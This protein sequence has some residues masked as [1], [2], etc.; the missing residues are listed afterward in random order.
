MRRVTWRNW[1]A[2]ENNC[3]I[4]PS[5]S[6]GDHSRSR[7]HP[8]RVAALVSRTI[9]RLQPDPLVGHQWALTSGNRAREH[10]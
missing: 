10:G 9:R 4:D 3:S 8:A 6:R 7:S 1:A 2:R 5:P